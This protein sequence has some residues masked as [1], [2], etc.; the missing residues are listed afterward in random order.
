MTIG[1]TIKQGFVK[2]GIKGKFLGGT[3]K[4]YGNK[5]GIAQKSI[6]RQSK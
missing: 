6:R 2:K 4:Q 1:K 3:I 5:K